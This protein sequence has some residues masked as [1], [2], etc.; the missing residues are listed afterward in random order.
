MFVNI[1]RICENNVITQKL[2]FL[3]P[4][5]DKAIFLN[6][7]LNRHNYT[8]K[9]CYQVEPTTLHLYVK[10]MYIENFFCLSLKI[11][12]FELCRCSRICAIYSVTCMGKVWTWYNKGKGYNVP[13]WFQLQIGFNCTVING[14]KITVKWPM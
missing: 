7:L 13:C 3:L 6:M 4:S 8:L 11:S 1:S 9:N 12:V 5:E 2:S 14:R 10:I